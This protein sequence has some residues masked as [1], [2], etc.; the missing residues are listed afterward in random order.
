MK[1]RKTK[2]YAALL[3]V[4]VVGLAGGY[5]AS[6]LVGEDG[7]SGAGKDRKVLYW[8]SPMNPSYRSDKPGKSPMGMDLVPVYAD[9]QT[10][11]ESIDLRISPEVVDNLGVRTEQVRMG[12]LPHRIN[13]VGY[14]GYD[15]DTVFSVHTRADGWIE[16][17]GVKSKGDKVVAGELLYELFSPKLATA[18]QEYLTALESGSKSLISASGD[19]LRSLGFSDDQVRALAMTRRVTKRVARRA[20]NAGVIAALGVTEGAYVT[21]GTEVMKIA[22]LSQVWMLVEIDESSAAVVS[23]GQKAVAR[24]DAFPGRKWDGVVDYVY[25]TM[26]SRTRTIKARIRFDNPNESLRPNMYGHAD[27]LANPVAGAVYVPTQALIRTGQSERVVVALGNG[28]FDVCPVETGFDSGEF[29]QILR[30]LT[31]GQRVVVSAQFM[32]D[33]EANVDAA[34][35]RLG[36]GKAGCRTSAATPASASHA[37]K[38]AGTG[39]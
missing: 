24:F 13:A 19:R 3:S 29:T 11:K 33:S 35:L 36:A 4:L 31:P 16:K 18:E 30:G 23:S 27:I 14:V 22:D 37:A 10:Q 1:S 26:N 34:S 32:I 12:V 6:H 28:R 25:P 38:T 5:Y 7:G 39:S 17:L 20:P 15:E 9:S 21:P 8:V 2:I